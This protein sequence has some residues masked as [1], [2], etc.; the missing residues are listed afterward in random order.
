LIR[1]R[2]PSIEDDAPQAV[3][4]VL[5][6]GY[7]VQGPRVA[8]FERAIGEYLEIEHAVAVTSCAAD[9]VAARSPTLP[10][11]ESLMPGGPG[12]GRRGAERRHE[13]IWGVRRH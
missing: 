3:R 11:Y 8:D 5:E 1:L 6:T 2:I 10:L 7:L 4:D 9:D 12:A 13:G